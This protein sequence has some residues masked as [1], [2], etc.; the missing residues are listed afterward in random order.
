MFNAE[1]KKKKISKGIWGRDQV[2]NAIIFN[3]YCS[4]VLI[5]DKSLNSYR[6]IF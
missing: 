5:S 1:C 2:R 3:A 6:S 4:D